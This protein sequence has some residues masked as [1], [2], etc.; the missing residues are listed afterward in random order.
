[1]TRQTR[2]AVDQRE[3]G[4]CRLESSTVHPDESISGFARW[5]WIGPDRASGGLWDGFYR[6]LAAED[7][8]PLAKRKR[9]NYGEPYELHALVGAIFLLVV[10]VAEA[11]SPPG[12]IDHR[13]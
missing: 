11:Q 5:M 2:S 4:L 1:V 13:V 9:L 8:I 7:L 12:E 3:P 10:T 6:C